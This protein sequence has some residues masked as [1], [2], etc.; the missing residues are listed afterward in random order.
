MRCKIFFKNQIIN[1]YVETYYNGRIR[2]MYGNENDKKNI[3]LDLKKIYLTS[4]K[5]AINPEIVKNNL[6]HLLIKEKIIKNIV[7][8][9][10]YKGSEI[11]ICSINLVYSFSSSLISASVYDFNLES[12]S[13]CGS[14]PINS[15][16]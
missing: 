16:P 9:I 15:S 13:S 8:S 5:V 6:F 3:T 12:A 14:Y 10:N 7:S 11:P 1:I 2:L 4:D